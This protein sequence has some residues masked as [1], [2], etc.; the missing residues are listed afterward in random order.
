[1][2]FK[3][4]PIIKHPVHSWILYYCSA[5]NGEGTFLGGT[6]PDSLTSSGQNTSVGVATQTMTCRF[7]NEL[8]QWPQHLHHNNNM[9]LW[10]IMQ[11]RRKSNQA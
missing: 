7:S 6:I 11:E 9:P 1:L 4:S 8:S 10:K 2:A 3:P 5:K